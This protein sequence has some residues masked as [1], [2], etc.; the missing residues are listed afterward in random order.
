M[1]RTAS[2]TLLALVGF[3]APSLA[4][5][6]HD[7]FEYALSTDRPD[8]AETSQVIEPEQYQIEQGIRVARADDGTLTWQTPSLHRIGLLPGWE[9]RLETDGLGHDGQKFGMS[10]VSLGLKWH[11]LDGGDWGD[12]PSAAFLIDATVPSAINLARVQNWDPTAKLLM[13]MDLPMGFG[14]GLNLGSGATVDNTG[15]YQATW[16]YAL[17]LDYDLSEQLRSYV[18]ISGDRDLPILLDGGFAYL[19]TPDVQLDLAIARDV[20]G[21]NLEWAGGLGISSRF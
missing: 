10:D 15:V 7:P 13:D 5:G 11:I 6:D 19:V 17:A 12:V 3:A 8:I 4:C 2:A 1:R 9:A 14:L 20:L 16:L 18:E 21:S